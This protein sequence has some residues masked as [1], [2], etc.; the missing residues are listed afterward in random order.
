MKE[1]ICGRKLVKFFGEGSEK[2][3]VLDEVDVSVAK[4]EFLSVMGPSGSGKSTL[5]YTLSGMDAIDGGTVS[6]CGRDLAVCREEELADLRRTRMGFVFQQP[7]L[8]KN[9]NLLDNIIFPSLRSH[10]RNGAE[11]EEKAKALMERTGILPLAQRSITQTSGGQLQ[12]AGICRALMGDPEIIF[13]D[14]PTGALNSSAAEEIMD[15]FSEINAQG[16]AVMMVTHDPKIAAR[17]GRI[18]FLADGRTAGELR[19][20]EASANVSDIAKTSAKVNDITKAS[21]K[22]SVAAKASSDADK[23]RF[24]DRIDCILEKMRILGI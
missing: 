1:I 7:A 10:G 2:R 4:G 5:L 11:A 19:F 8:L 14:E 9:L 23:L 17:A 21:A 6:F 22:V 12:R 20:P 15:I 16:T 13:A 24:Q 3:K 18:L